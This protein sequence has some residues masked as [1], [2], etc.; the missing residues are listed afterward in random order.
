M[1]G[2]GLRQVFGQ[3]RYIV[4]AAAT[5]LAVFIFATWLPNLGLVWHIAASGS[6]PLADK[7]RILTALVGSIGT[8]FTLFSGL[9]T[10]AI[11]VL[12]GANTALIVYYIRL[13]RDLRRTGQ[14]AA[15]SIAGL[16]SGLFGVGCAAC[17]TLALGPVASFIGVGGLVAALPFGGEEL[18]VVGIAMLGLSLMLTARKIGEPI[19]CPIGSTGSSSGR[20]RASPTA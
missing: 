17:G 3:A 11:A 16:T 15:T 18:G 9:S 10:A 13:R 20:N 5:G 19:A 14:G 2:A 6:I 7:A 12:F 4:L 8:N 1:V